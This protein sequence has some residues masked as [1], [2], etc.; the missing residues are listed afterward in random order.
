MMVIFCRL[1]EEV[2][3]W[4][5]AINCVT[6]YDEELVEGMAELLLIQTKK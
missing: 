3:L 4:K 6:I 5:K 2:N 1:F